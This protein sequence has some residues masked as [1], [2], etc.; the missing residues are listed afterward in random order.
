MV[1][2]VLLRMLRSEAGQATLEFAVAGI[3]MI[4]LIFGSIAAFEGFVGRLVVTDAARSA[5]RYASIHCDPASLAYDPNWTTAVLSDVEASLRRGGL[6]VGSYVQG[7][8]LVRSGDW[9][10]RASCAGGVAEVE[11]FY[12]QTNLWG[13]EPY[14]LESAASFPTE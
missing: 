5:A 14:R 9:S 1:R 3:A 6:K 2:R 4:V 10:V 8:S 7:G 13:G 12:A 11:V